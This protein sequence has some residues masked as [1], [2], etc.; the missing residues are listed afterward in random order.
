M[1]GTMIAKGKRMP[2]TAENLCQVLW[3]PVPP[4]VKPYSP[5]VGKPAKSKRRH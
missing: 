5:R 2:I 3:P 1:T 4:K